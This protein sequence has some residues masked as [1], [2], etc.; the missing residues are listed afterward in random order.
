MFKL[1]E[2]VLTLARTGG[3]IV[4][5]V[6]YLYLRQIVMAPTKGWFSLATE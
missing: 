2:L 1:D 3:K 4:A 6:N 5:Q